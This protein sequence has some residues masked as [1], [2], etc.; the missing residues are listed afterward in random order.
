MNFAGNNN[1]G[2]LKHFYEIYRVM[3][4]QKSNN[5]RRDR[6][7][8]RKSLFA[9]KINKIRKQAKA[10]SLQVTDGQLVQEDILSKTILTKE[11]EETFMRSLRALG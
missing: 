10:S 3:N 1:I 9:S 6:S 2:G 4:K 7:A 8:S 11:Q 5:G